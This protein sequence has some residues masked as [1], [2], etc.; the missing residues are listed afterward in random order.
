MHRY[1]QVGG[2]VALAAVL[3]LFAAP[4]GRSVVYATHG[5]VATA[6]PIATQIGLD[7]LKAGGSAVDACVAANAALGLMEPTSCGIGGDLFAIVYDAK[8]K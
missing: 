4:R 5:M 1:R 8:T 2:L 3:P 6:H 7:V